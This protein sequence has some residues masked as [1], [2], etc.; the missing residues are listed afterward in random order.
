MSED[1]VNRVFVDANVLLD[2]HDDSRI[3]HA[4]SLKAI[5]SLA[6]GYYVELYTSCDIITT[7]YYVL[8]KSNKA[9]A[10]EMIQ[11]ISEL[12]EIVE[13]SNKEV[14]ES[15]ELMV[16]DKPRYKDLEDTIQLV[17]A[18]KAQCQLILSNDK[19]FVSPEIELMTTKQFVSSTG[20]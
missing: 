16:S 13:F 14:I 17:L 15:C 11:D 1:T 2:L 7:L 5:T 9:R 18:Q 10:L 20:S 3:S 19:G 12:C 4:D 6:E 8:S